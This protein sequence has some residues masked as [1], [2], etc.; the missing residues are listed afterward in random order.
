MRGGDSEQERAKE[1][2]LEAI[3]PRSSLETRQALRLLT[4]AYCRVFSTIFLFLPF[5]MKSS[6]KSVLLT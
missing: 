6:L 5:L 1:G 3:K 4:I 2:S